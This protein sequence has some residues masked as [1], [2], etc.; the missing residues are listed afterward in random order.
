M[1]EDSGGK[2]MAPGLKAA[3][4]A[5]AAVWIIVLVVLSRTHRI[6]RSP[7]PE[8]VLPV[9]PKAYQVDLRSFPDRDWSSADYFVPLD[10]PSME[11]FRYYDERMT[12][13]GWSRVDAR[14]LSEWSVTP[15][16][17]GKHAALTASWLGPNRLLRLDLQLTWDS[18]KD[19]DQKGAAAP[20]MRVSASM[21]RNYVPATATPPLREE[22][23]PATEETPFAR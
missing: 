2:R 17:G 5:L 22:Q 10:Y 11:V 21:A 8:A 15:R 18:P 23:P 6:A 4:V 12:Q 7:E 13:Q 20:K 16:D 19:G 14:G 3:M 9:Y 1:P